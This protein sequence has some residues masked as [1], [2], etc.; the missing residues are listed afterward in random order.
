[1]VHNCLLNLLNNTAVLCEVPYMSKLKV[2]MFQHTYFIYIRTLSTYIRSQ[3]KT[4][5]SFGLLFVNNFAIQF[6][7]CSVGFLKHVRAHHGFQGKTARS[8]VNKNC[9]QQ[10]KCKHMHLRT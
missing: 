10:V 9:S 5:S 7:F 6:Q 3:G 4:D 1:M 2:I 8:A